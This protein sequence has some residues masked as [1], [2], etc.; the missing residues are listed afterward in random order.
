MSDKEG[1]VADFPSEI[2]IEGKIQVLVPKL[3]AYGVLPSV[4]RLL[5]HLC[6]TIR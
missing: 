2:I 1:Y 5:K 3:E 4:M 6:S